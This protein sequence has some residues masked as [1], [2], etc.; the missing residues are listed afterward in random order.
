MGR[1]PVGAPAIIRYVNNSLASV[2]DFSAIDGDMVL[3]KTL[4]ASGD[5]TLSFV[6]GTS[7]VVFDSTY[8]TYIFKYIN[9]NPA[10]DNAAL[11]FQVDTGTNTSYNQTMTTTSF[12][13]HH[14]EGDTETALGYETGMD[15]A[16]GSG[17][18]MLLQT[19]AGNGADES[20][21]GELWI[22]NPSSTTYVKHFISR[23][24]VYWSSNGSTA[25]FVGG[26]VNTT[27]ALTRVQFKPESG[28]FD[29]T[30]KMYGIT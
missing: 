18:Q 1:G 21:S 20:G 15:Q 9:I 8:K 4:T 25:L 11:G 3:I 22:F 28:N 19:N 14:D 16:Q 13:A 5:S 26:Y 6:N 2:D 24:N 27:T 23:S 30:I 10:T 7:D 12:Q 29:G 17:F